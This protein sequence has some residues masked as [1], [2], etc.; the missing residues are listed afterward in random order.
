MIFVSF[1]CDA[2]LDMLALPHVLPEL[3]CPATIFLI[4]KFVEK[5]PAIAASLRSFD[6]VRV[7]NHTYSHPWNEVWGMDRCFPKLPASERRMEIARGHE[8]IHNI[9]GVNCRVFRS[10]HFLPLAD[11]DLRFLSEEMG[12]EWDSSTIG[13]ASA[14]RL[15]S[16]LVEIPV[17]RHGAE[18]LSNWVFL[19]R[20]RL[21]TGE[22]LSVLGSLFERDNPVNMYLDPRYLVEVSCLGEI[23]LSEEGRHMVDFLNAHADR[24]ALY[25]E[26]EAGRKAAPA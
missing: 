1:D 7:G 12:Y 14:T 4:G 25:E 3:R 22:F 11:A 17:T 6:H 18:A 19:H 16:G 2:D 5:Y 10:P 24:M 8:T 13:D 9:C 15:P 23:R 21:S 26:V 20:W